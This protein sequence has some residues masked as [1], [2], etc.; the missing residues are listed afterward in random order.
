MTRRIS[1]RALARTQTFVHRALLGVLGVGVAGLLVWQTRSVFGNGANTAGDERT[2]NVSVSDA[3]RS[4]YSDSFTLMH[5]AVPEGNI[6][7]EAI[8]YTPALTQSL[9]DYTNRSSHQEELSRFLASVD[10]E[11]TLAFSVLLTT[12]VGTVRDLPVDDHATVRDDTGAVYAILG[13]QRL[14]PLALA[15]TGAQKQEAGVLLV[16]TVAEDGTSVWTNGGTLSLILS[17]IEQNK[18]VFT[19]QKE[20]ANDIN[21]L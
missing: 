7:A 2:T 17:D 15:P 20:L 8:W 6:L 12:E 10:H 11:T 16:S 18:K 5:R 1:I 19:W 13:W 21:L 3:A 14:D 4:A 9:A